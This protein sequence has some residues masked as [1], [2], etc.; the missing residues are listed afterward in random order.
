V[1]LPDL[2]G[3]GERAVVVLVMLIVL[4]GGV[5]VMTCDGGCGLPGDLVQRRAPALRR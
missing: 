2:R 5:A 4:R 1:R 3:I